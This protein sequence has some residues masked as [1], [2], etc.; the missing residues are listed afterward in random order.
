MENFHLMPADHQFGVTLGPNEYVI[1]PFAIPIL[2]NEYGAEVLD[3]AGGEILDLS[4]LAQALHFEAGLGT[5]AQGLYLM[6]HLVDA[7]TLARMVPDEAQ[8]LIAAAMVADAFGAAEG[9]PSSLP[10]LVPRPLL[11]RAPLGFVL[12]GVFRD[13]TEPDILSLNRPGWW[14]RSTARR[15]CEA[16]IARQLPI[17]WTAAPAAPAA[18]PVAACGLREALLAGLIELLAPKQIMPPSTVALEL[19]G[20]D[21]V[22]MKTDWPSV[23]AKVSISRRLLGDQFVDDLLHMLGGQLDM[24]TVSTWH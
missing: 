17:H 9:A 16:A 22:H 12:G 5:S 3:Q 10:P 24:A 19:S 15:S 11:A 20:A 2:V 8:S 14:Q 21:L 18:M 6:P 4:S 13:A 1:A 23:E 7:Q